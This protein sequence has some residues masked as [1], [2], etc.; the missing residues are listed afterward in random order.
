MKIKPW[1]YRKEK[2]KSIEFIENIYT[3]ISIFKVSTLMAQ[4][5]IEDEF[6]TRMEFKIWNP[7]E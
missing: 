6:A 1:E 2:G 4:H 7:K 5:K 3:K